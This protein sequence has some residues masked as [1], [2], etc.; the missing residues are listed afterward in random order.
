MRIEDYAEAINAE[1]QVEYVPGF[2]RWHAKFRCCETSDGRFLTSEFGSGL[3]PTGA[4]KEYCRQLQG[5]TLVFNAGY[6]KYRREFVAP[7]E[8]TYDV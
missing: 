8:L 1:L 3:T 6:I 4:I 2:R 5:K 7:Q